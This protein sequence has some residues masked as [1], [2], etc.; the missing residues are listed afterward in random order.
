MDFIHRGYSC[1]GMAPVWEATDREVVPLM[2]P[3]LPSDRSF[4]SRL[5]ARALG[6]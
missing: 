4:V 5:L 2:V 6:G 1:S 3:Q